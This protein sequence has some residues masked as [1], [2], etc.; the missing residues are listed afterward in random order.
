MVNRSKI[1]VTGATGNVGAE[2]VKLL[3]QAGQPTVAAV[4][5]IEKARQ[6][7]GNEIEYTL[8]DFKQP[9]TYQSA[10]KGIKKLFLVRPPDISN[11]KKYVTP[12]IQA[13]KQ[14]G[15]EHIVFLSLLGAEKNTIV[16]HYKIEQ[17]LMEV[18]IDWTFLRASFF[19]ENLSTTHLEEIK[20]RNEIFIPA[21]K[22]KTSFID[23]GDIATV[24]VKALTEEGHRRQAYPL[25]GSEALD[26]FEVARQFSEVLGRPIHYANPSAISFGWRMFRNKMPLPLIVVMIAIYTTARLDRAGTVTPDIE[27]LLGRPPTTLRQYIQAHKEVWL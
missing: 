20:E 18:G 9:Q 8:F 15:V 13:A 7:L 3:I 21:G 22:G 4:R 19:M 2:V 12:A 23:V 5:N 6:L 27:R 26:Y 14:A 11:V 24:A 10:F 17:A 16:P 25:T 1:L